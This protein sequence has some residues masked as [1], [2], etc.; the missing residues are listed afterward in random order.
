[1]LL[2]KM[3]GPVN[4]LLN[5]QVDWIRSMAMFTRIFEYYDMPVEIKNAPDAIT[6]T[7]APEGKV[8]FKNVGFYYDK[9]RQILSD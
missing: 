2:G 9:E 3:Y 4:Q 7:D 5:I 6:P 8:E 1:A